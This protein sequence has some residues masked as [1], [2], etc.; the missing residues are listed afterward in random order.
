[1]EQLTSAI[2]ECRQSELLHLSGH[3]MVADTQFVSGPLVF[4]S[5]DLDLMYSQLLKRFSM[6]QSCFTVVMRPSM[7][8]S[9]NLGALEVLT[10]L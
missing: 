6:K 3:D 1:M 7:G 4:L 9:L 2:Q 8:I 5:V 10:L